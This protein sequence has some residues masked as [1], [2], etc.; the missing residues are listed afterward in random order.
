MAKKLITTALLLVFL[1]CGAWLNIA[2]NF[3]EIAD[4]FEA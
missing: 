3:G 1:A 4:D 2:Q